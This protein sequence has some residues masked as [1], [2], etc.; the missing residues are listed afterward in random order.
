MTED[1]GV[2][3]RFDMVMGGYLKIPESPA[4]AVS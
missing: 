3:V 4:A 1:A 2:Q